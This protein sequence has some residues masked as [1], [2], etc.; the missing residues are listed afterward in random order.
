MKEIAG[1][2]PVQSIMLNDLLQKIVD[3]AKQGQELCQE[4]HITRWC[5]E[6][7]EILSD[8]ELVNPQYVC[9]DDLS[10]KL[11]SHRIMNPQ[12]MKKVLGIL[13]RILN[14]SKKLEKMVVPDHKTYNAIG[15]I[16]G[17]AEQELW[18]TNPKNWLSTESGDESRKLGSVVYCERE[19]P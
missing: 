12:R 19:E 11:W 17:I 9:H 18:S 2:N 5:L 14:V 4:D 1:S 10:K 3:A 8:R 16:K 7:I 13:H 6:V 15:I